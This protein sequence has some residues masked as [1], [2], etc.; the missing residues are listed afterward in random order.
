MTRSHGGELKPYDPEMREH[1]IKGRTPL[2]EAKTV[3]KLIQKNNLQS[4]NPLWKSW[5]LFN[6]VSND[7]VRL[8]IFPFSLCDTAK[9]WLQPLPAS[10]ITTWAALTQNSREQVNAIFVRNK[11]V[12]ADEPPKEQVEEAHAQKEEESQE[13]TKGSPL[14]LN[15][16]MPSSTK[17]LKEVLENKK[18]WEECEMVKRNEESSAIL[19]NKLPPKLK[20]PGSFSIPCTIENIDFDKVLCDLGA[21]VNLMPYSIFEKLGMH[22]LTP[23]IITL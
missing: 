5:E 21:S 20:D 9:D 4:L 19:Q 16:D 1:S 12:I 7:I 8:R 14:K 11:K 18:R 15:L 3:E 17:F 10:S 2:K 6:G 13:E 23:T 22:E